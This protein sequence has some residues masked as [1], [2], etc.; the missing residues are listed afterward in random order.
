MSSV[1]S[2]NIPPIAWQLPRG[3]LGTRL[4]VNHKPWP[5]HLHL[6]NRLGQLVKLLLLLLLLCL[7][8]LWGRLNPRLCQ[9][10]NNKLEA[11][12]LELSLSVLNDEKEMM[13][14]G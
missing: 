9:T 5:S 11:E 13:Q 12:L 8:L 1:L 10:T 2:L 3:L 7:N 14:V 4:R 6:A